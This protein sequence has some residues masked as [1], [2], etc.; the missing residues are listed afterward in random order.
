VETIDSRKLS[1]APTTEG[2]L[3][4]CGTRLAQAL[5]PT[6][7]GFG[8]LASRAGAPA[9]YLRTLQPDTA[10]LCLNEGLGHPDRETN[11]SM[12][13]ARYDDASGE[14]FMHA[15]T[16]PTYGRIWDAEVVDL[17][18]NIVD[19]TGGRFYNPKEW[20]GAPSGLYASDRDVFM[21]LID[22]G[23]I[24]DGGGA[25]DQLH[26]GFF[27]SNSEVGKAT[28]W[29]AAFLFREVCGNHQLWGVEQTIEL[30]IKH[31]S[32]A[33]ARF[34]SEASK[35]LLDHVSASAKPLEEIIHKAKAYE[36]PYTPDLNNLI[37]WAAKTPAQ[38]TRGE[39]KSAVAYCQREEGADPS[40]LW[41]LQQGLTAYARDIAYMDA[42][43]DVER[44]A[45]KLMKLAA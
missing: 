23:S 35:A 27:V 31:T 17:V 5:V 25:R 19:S 10:A 32:G 16:G 6:H 7:W 37:E 13:L 12:I 4:L 30:K 22:G 40:N 28:L 8:Q 44:R 26:R 9:G 11:Q 38:L 20:G 29:L 2:G 18:Q 36:L 21:F 3:A 34:V 41:L 15:D 45:G 24:V 42:R 14:T 1:V 33:P 43:V 39:V